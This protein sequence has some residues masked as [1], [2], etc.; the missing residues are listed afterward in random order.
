MILTLWWALALQTAHGGALQVL[1]LTVTGACWH[2]RL[3]TLPGLVRPELAELDAARPP[4]CDPT[5]IC[6]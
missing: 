2:Q 1:E 4:A 3:G 5:S 6:S